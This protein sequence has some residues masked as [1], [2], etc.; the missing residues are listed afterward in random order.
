[1]SALDEAR[2]VFLLELQL[3]Q[4]TR[5]PRPYTNASDEDGASIDAYRRPISQNEGEQNLALL[6]A[7]TLAWEAE[8]RGESRR[9][10]R[11]AS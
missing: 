2:R 8:H 9:H 1:M 3:E 6:N 7:E 4:A 10:L 11:A 5:R